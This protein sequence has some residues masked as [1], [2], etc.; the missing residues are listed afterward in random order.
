MEYGKYQIKTTFYKGKNLIKTNHS[1]HSNSAVIRAV[2]HMQT[3]QYGATVAE[4]YDE[5]SGELHAVLTRSVSGM[6]IVFKR[7][8]EGSLHYESK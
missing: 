4:V 1:K 6:K 2:G 3:N 8:I 5:E 7:E